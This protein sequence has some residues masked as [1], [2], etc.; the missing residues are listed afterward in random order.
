MLEKL[1]EDLRSGKIALPSLAITKQLTKEPEDYP[2]K[3]SLP[4]VQVP[5]SSYSSSIFQLGPFVNDVTHL[6]R[7]A[8]G[9]PN[10]VNI[11]LRL[12]IIA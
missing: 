10:L 2:D 1:A 4:H 12:K 5:C 11:C 7:E 3:R 9:F 8:L 6:E